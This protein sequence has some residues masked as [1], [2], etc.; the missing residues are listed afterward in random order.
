MDT[1]RVKNKTTTVST[2]SGTMLIAF[3]IVIFGLC[4]GLTLSPLILTFIKG[5]V[6]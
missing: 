1:T 6:P 2:S 3:I 4:I 5:C